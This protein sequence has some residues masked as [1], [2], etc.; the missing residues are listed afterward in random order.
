MYVKVH[1]ET[2][3]NYA[4]ELPTN[5][6]NST[7]TIPENSLGVAEFSLNL[8]VNFSARHIKAK[9]TLKNINN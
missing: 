3:S 5:Q 6:F 7:Q 9:M 4:K 8:N 2:S 1:A